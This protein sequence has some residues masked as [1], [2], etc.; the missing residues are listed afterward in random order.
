MP[1]V[2]KHCFSRCRVIIDCTE[3]KCKTPT[4]NVLN[5]MFYFQYKSHITIKGLVGIAPFGAMPF[6][7]ELYTRLTFDKEITK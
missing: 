5:S 1:D 2:F 7:S 4:A 6:V 3:I